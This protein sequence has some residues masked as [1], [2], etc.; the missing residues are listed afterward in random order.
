MEEVLCQDPKH[1]EQSMCPIRD[2]VVR[3]YGVSVMTAFTDNP[4]YTYRVFESVAVNE[5]S[6]CPV[7]V[8]VDVTFTSGSAD[9]TSLLRWNKLGHKS[10]KEDF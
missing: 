10:V 7:V 2:D 5:V 9:R 1:K 6:Y 4:H 8:C 3:K